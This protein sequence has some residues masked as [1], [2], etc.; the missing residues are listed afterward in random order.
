MQHIPHTQRPGIRQHDKS[1]IA[2]RLVVVKLVLR[3]PEADEGIV[4]PA[5]LSYHVP[6]T[7]DGAED[8]LG[9]VVVVV[10]S[11]RFGA[12]CYCWGWLAGG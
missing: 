3:R 2:R 6:E 7:E 9:C 1:R 10:A 4:L 12:V 5:Q 11:Y 8:E